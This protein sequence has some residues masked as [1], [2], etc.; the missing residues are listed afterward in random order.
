VPCTAP[1]RGY[2]PLPTAETRKLVFSA[3]EGFSDRPVNVP[4]GKCNGCI[5]DRA[6]DWAIRAHCEAQ[7]HPWSTFATFTYAE[8]PARASLSMTDWQN[9]AKRM[10]EAFGPFRF[11]TSGE[12]GTRYQRPHLHSLLFGLDFPDKVPSGRSASG[13]LLYRSPELEKVWDF[14]RVDLGDVTVKSAGYVARYSAEK[15][16]AASIPEY[17]RRVDP[18]S[19]ETWN[20]RPEFITMS[21][22]PGLGFSWFQRFGSEV[23]PADRITIHGTHYPV[24]EYFLRQL[25]E[26]QQWAVRARRHARAEDRMRAE[27]AMHVAS[28]PD[29]LASTSRLFTKHQVGQL[30][31]DRLIRA[32]GEV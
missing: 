7:M 20:V 31:A 25:S 15:I 19:G 2:R 23:F 28:N 18:F 26:A 27:D 17:Y 12:Y 22:R 32:G 30:R 24:P 6:R 29:P 10:R 14:G 4:C 3:R 21:R 16:E 9:L 11:L 5:G 1:G 13:E 8:M